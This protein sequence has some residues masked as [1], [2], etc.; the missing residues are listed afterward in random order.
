M[1]ATIEV[2]QSCPMMVKQKVTLAIM[3]KHFGIQGV[4]SNVKED[5]GMA[6]DLKSA[7]GK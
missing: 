7:V 5:L 1:N 2:L 4:V 6:V 3:I